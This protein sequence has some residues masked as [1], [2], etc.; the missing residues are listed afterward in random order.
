MV[1]EFVA[2][3]PALSVTVTPTVKFPVSVGVQFMLDSLE[4]AHPTGKGAQSK[5]SPGTPPVMI[6]DRFVTLPSTK[7]DGFATTRTD[8][9]GDIGTISEDNG[10]A[11]TPKP[12]PDETPLLSRMGGD[13]TKVTARRAT[14][15]TR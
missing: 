11:E 9:G 4:P 3:F 8:S 5:R 12:V 10:T 7:V 13:T 14:S 15:Q 1:V 6:A 2:L